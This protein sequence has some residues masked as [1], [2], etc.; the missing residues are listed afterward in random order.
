MRTLPDIA[1]ACGTRP[2]VRMDRWLNIIFGVVYSLIMLAVNR[3]VQGA[4]VLLHHVRLNR[5][6]ID[7][8]YRLVCVDLAQRS[9][10]PVAPSHAQLI[11]SLWTSLPRRI[12]GITG[13]PEV[14]S[15]YFPM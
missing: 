8:T 7:A 13:N 1:E 2:P 4:L 15:C 6:H 5:N 12:V 11:G 9:K 14:L 10:P 3:R